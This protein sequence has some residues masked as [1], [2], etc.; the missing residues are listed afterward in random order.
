MI[1]N[2]KTA[3]HASILSSNIIIIK[4]LQLNIK[5]I[6]YSATNLYIYINFLTS[7]IFLSFV[8]F[9]KYKNFINELLRFLKKIAA[10]KLTLRLSSFLYFFF[11]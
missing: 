10:S 3:T 9:S 2:I 5:Y 1:N 8:T 6:E 7:D 11:T 4:I